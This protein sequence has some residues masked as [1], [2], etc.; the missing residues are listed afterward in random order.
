MARKTERNI[1][2]A[3]VLEEVIVSPETKCYLNR[4][5]SLLYVLARISS[6]LDGAE[7][8]KPDYKY[9]SLS[10]ISATGRAELRSNFYRQ[11]SLAPELT[12][13]PTYLRKGQ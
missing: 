7:E 13:F 4:L 11:R 1:I 8:I 2:S 6:H 12:V 3:V 5:S 9:P 10:L